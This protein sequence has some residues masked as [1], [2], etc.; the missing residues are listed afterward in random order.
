MNLVYRIK[1]LILIACDLTSYLAGLWIGLL[2]RYVKLPGWDDIDRHLTIFIIVFILW[3][4]INYI[5]GLYDLVRVHNDLKTY[6]RLMETTF[7]S[8]VIGIIF[9]YLLPNRALTPKTILLF[10][11]IFGYG[12]SAILRL[13]YNIII[14]QRRL[15]TKVLFIGHAAEVEELIGIMANQPEK[16]YKAVAVIDSNEKIKSHNN[17]GVDIYHQLKT[18]RPAI[19]NHKAQLIV[20]APHLKQNE[21]VLRELYELL[22]WPVQMIDLMSFYELLT[23]RIPPTTFSESWFLDHLKNTDQPIYDKFRAFVDIISGIIMGAFFII[24]LPLAALGIKFASPGPIFFK[25]KRIGKYGQ[26]FILYKFRSMYA[27]SDDGSAELNGAQFAKKKD[28]RAT[29]IGKLLRRTRLD[30][31]PQILNLLKRDITLIGPRPERPEIVSQLTGR[32]PYYPLRHI[33]RPGLTGWAVL[34]QNYTD[35]LETSLQ[36]LQYDLY[37]IKNRSSLLDLSILLRTINVIV[38]M[39]GQ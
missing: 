7:L 22:F 26:E 5:N 34:H 33:V 11:V 21:E 18:I 24:I 20:V 37:Y 35:T 38:R 27:L 30:E 16:G 39:R 29:P 12:I 17:N 8:L 13:L 1:Q 15:Q 23:G 10:N 9:F 6:R 32:M 3:L 19:T 2:I 28:A 31:L 36:K 25:Q 14:G 4:T